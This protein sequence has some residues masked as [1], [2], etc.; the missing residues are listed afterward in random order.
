MPFWIWNLF[1]KDFYF[2]KF[3]HLS[4]K[5]IDYIDQYIIKRVKSNNNIYIII[6]DT[7]EG[8]AYLNF[9]IVNNFVKTYQLE[10]K[11]IYVTSHLDVNKEYEIWIKNKKV[12]KE[13]FVYSHNRWF[14]RVH[15]LITEKKISV[16]VDKSI[17][18]C[19]MNNRP[20]D[21]RLIA[22]TYLDFLKM[23]DH[24]LVSANDRDYENN[25]PYTYK[26][27]ILTNLNILDETY[28]NII[29]QQKYITAKKLPLISDVK[30]LS[31]KCLPDDIS[32]K[33]YN[34]TLINLVTET[35]YFNNLNKFSE[36][37]ISEKSWKS[38][39]AKQIPIIIGPRGIISRIR[40]F[41]FDMFDDIV[42]HS[43]DNEPDSTRL[44]SAINSL[45]TI[46]K[47]CNITELSNLTRDRREKNFNKMIAGIEL[48]EPIW[49]VID[50][51]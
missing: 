27:I 4:K 7:I 51:Y 25:A 15:D 11:I 41:G 50:V 34:N 14:W 17:W 12:K 45:N 44:F 29:Q 5:P 49:K 38:F 24:G 18:Y 8:Y 22:I 39:T 33:I 32:S 37:F 42:D 19:C 9:D 3:D 2:Y 48:D 40:D 16:S 47:N 36:M 1:R 21:H 28:A 13:F 30:I 20:R 10:N 26:D 6:D 43:Y 35:Y 31:K 46:I 23:F